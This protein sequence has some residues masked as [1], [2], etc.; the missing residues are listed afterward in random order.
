MTQATTD[1]TK[2]FNLEH[3][4]RKSSKSSN[5]NKVTLI[6]LNRIKKETF[7]Q[8]WTKMCQIKYEI[9]ETLF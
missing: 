9:S 1:K 5:Q 8:N 7:Y 2:Y 3:I 6:F 4:L